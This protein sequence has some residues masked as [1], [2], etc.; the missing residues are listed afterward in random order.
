MDFR[1]LR[2]FITVAEESSVTKA[3]ERLHISQ[4]PL[5]RHIK[6]LEDELGITLFVRHRQ[7]VTL[8][9]AGQRLLEKARALASAA[10]DFY[11]SA[12]QTTRHVA[13][14]VRLGIGWGQWDTVNRIRVASAAQFGNM[15]IEATDAMCAEHYNHQ[16]QDGSLDVLFGWPYFDPEITEAVPLYQQPLLAVLSADHPLASRKTL[17]V[18]DLAS[19][20]LL[21]YDRHV[22]PYLYDKVLALYAKAGINPRLVPTPDAGPYNQAGLMLVASGKGIYVCMGI[23]LTSPHPLSGIAVVPIS[24]P[25]AT[26]DIC[27]AWRKGE[28]SPV[29]RQFLNCVWQVFPDAERVPVAVKTASRRAS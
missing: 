1:H 17:C 4:P 16:L 5:S 29:V 25:E 24:D 9:D 7:G 28:T 27:V 3:A 21:M 15:T 13:N 11:E 8:T 23:P 10:S 20:P 22:T 26:V 14:K 12:N 2:A 18:R 6:Q 19:E